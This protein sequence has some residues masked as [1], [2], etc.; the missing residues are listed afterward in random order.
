MPPRK[1]TYSSALSD[2][3]PRS[4]N[5]FDMFGAGAAG[6]GAAAPPPGRPPPAPDELEA[7]KQLSSLQTSNPDAFAAMMKAALAEGGEAEVEELW[8]RAAADERAPQGVRDGEIELPGAKVLRPDGSVRAAA[9]AG[10]RCVPV[11]GFVL[12]TRDTAPRAELAAVGEEAAQKYFINVCGSPAVAAPSETT[13]LDASGQEVQGISVAVSIGPERVT[14]DSKDEPAIAVDCLMN[15]ELLAEANGD[16]SKRDFLC[17]I[18]LEYVE[19]KYKRRLDRKFKLPR[20]KY[21]GG[22]P[23]ENAQWVR[24]SAQPKV[25]AVRAPEAPAEKPILSKVSLGPKPQIDLFYL[26]EAGGALLPVHGSG[27]APG[28]D[29]EWPIITLDCRPFGFDCSSLP[30]S[31]VARFSV[32]RVAG[33]GLDDGYVEANPWLGAAA[34]V[35]HSEYVVSANLAG[36]HPARCTL[37]FVV[38]GGAQAVCVASHTRDAWV[39][40]VTLAVDLRPAAAGDSPDVGSKPWLVARAISADGSAPARLAAAKAAG[41]AAPGDRYHLDEQRATTLRLAKPPVG[42]STRDVAY[43]AVR[44][45]EIAARSVA[46]EA[47]GGR[48]DDAPLPEDRFH[49]ADIL[50]QHYISQREGQTQEKV[51]RAAKEREER[52]GDDNVEYL[53]MDDFRPGGKFSAKDDVPLGSAAARA[54]EAAAAAPAAAP[55][56]VPSGLLV[57]DAV[58]QAGRQLHGVTLSSNLFA[59]LL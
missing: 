21:K 48:G 7:L 25:T 38:D 37:P 3:A 29:D 43:A 22:S 8:K 30:L 41:D 53:D 20:L 47:M 56:A 50:S 19:G 26:A 52:K 5:T 59:E 51:D 40:E 42:A 11:P 18:A 28:A 39:A 46:A 13:R 6:A 16:A 2:D 23:E 4:N 14:T 24:E 12:K 15:S 55:A 57:S 31:L 27:G 9:E 34:R 10:V 45:A 36:R 1:K 54:L 17:S 49:Q 32:P 33:D 44:A 58:L 35:S